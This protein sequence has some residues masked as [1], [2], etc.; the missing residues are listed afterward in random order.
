[1]SRVRP[2]SIELHAVSTRAG[3]PGNRHRAD[4]CHRRVCAGSVE[5]ATTLLSLGYWKQCPASGVQFDFLWDRN[6]CNP[7]ARI[8]PYLTFN[9]DGQLPSKL[10][11]SRRL[12]AG[13]HDS[14]VSGGPVRC[15]SEAV[16][17][18]R[19]CARS[20]RTRLP[21]ADIRQIASQTPAVAGPRRQSRHE[22]LSGL[23][24]MRRR[25]FAII[26]LGLD[27]SSPTWELSS[28]F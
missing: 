11:G 28:E 9:F 12:I 25:R 26:F 14:P 3:S 21:E 23:H 18:V 15:Q 4:V 20:G 7:G 22:S 19:Q 6:R 10:T 5:F 2:L 17:G 13:L 16:L 27:L 8:S 24:Q 1:V